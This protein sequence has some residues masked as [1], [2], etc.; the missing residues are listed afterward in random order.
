MA[1]ALLLLALGASLILETRTT[2]FLPGHHGYLS[3]MAL[4]MA[5]NLDREHHYLLYTRKWVDADGVSGVDPHNRFPGLAFALIAGAESQCG[6]DPACEMFRGRILMLLFA[7]GA[8]VVSMLLLLE[9][10]GDPLLSAAAALL[11][12]SSFY[13]QYYNDM[14]FNDV[15]ALLGFLLVL[16]GIARYEKHGSGGLLAAGTILAIANGWQ[17]Y[18]ALVTWWILVALR[19]LWSEGLGKVVPGLLHHRATRVLAMGILWGGCILAFNVFNEKTALK[20]PAGDLPSVQSIE[21]R[22]GLRGGAEEFP[23]YQELRWSNFLN[24][25]ARRVMKATIPTRPLHGWVNETS[26]KGSSAAKMALLLLGGV[27]TALA[28]FGLWKLLWKLKAERVACL[29]ALLSGLLW[30]LGMR[31][32]T[33]FHDFQA[34]FYV[35]VAMILYLSILSLVPESARGWLA[36]AALA[37]FVFSAWDLARVKTEEG[38]PYESRTSDFAAIRKVTGENR[39]IQLGLTDAEFEQEFIPFR[40]YMARSF[41]SDASHA[42]FVIT[43]DRNH[44]SSTLTPANHELFLFKAAGAPSP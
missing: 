32:F 7:W 10:S 29:A 24:K 4:A 38:R 9:L 43:R 26:E 36:I 40:F 5:K 3:S 34:M 27:F 31:Q 1:G 33:A 6:D 42:E 8:L 30:C 37:I 13:L 18:A 15:P 19:I 12:F 35:G 44:A 11:G 23:D 17:A 2:G 22:L 16:L 41:Y 21:F 39:R 28:A 25:Q 20:L 14:V